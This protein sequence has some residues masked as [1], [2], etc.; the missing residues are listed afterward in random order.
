MGQTKQKNY[1]RK[2][3]KGLDGESTLKILFKEQH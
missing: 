2:V 1:K 3:E